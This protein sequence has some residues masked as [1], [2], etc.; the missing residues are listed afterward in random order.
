MV[1]AMGRGG[2]GGG[3]QIPMPG[4]WNCPACNDLVFAKNMACRRCGEAKPSA[5]SFAGTMSSRGNSQPQSASTNGQVAQAG[6]WYCPSCND[7]Q[8]A[9]NT[10]CR[11]CG[12]APPT[13][14]VD[15]G[16]AHAMTKGGS[17][18]RP[19]DWICP[20]CNDHVFARNDACRRC[21]TPR[22]GSEADVKSGGGGSSMGLGGVDVKP[23]DWYC[24]ACKDLQ[25][26]R[27]AQCRMCGTARPED[28]GFGAGL[29][30]CGRG[31]SRSPHRG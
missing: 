29:G 20:R 15:Q 28:G 11:R 27:N 23:G 14:D 24:P 4:D 16:G 5:G 26:A 22:P 13:T 3:G 31:R 10:A 9:R 25:F 21:S 1:G 17:G 2:G 7:L 18:L 12:A 8:F 19:G 30:A 6:D